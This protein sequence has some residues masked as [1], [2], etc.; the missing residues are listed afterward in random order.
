MGLR[1]LTGEETGSSKSSE[2]LSTIGELSALRL[3]RRNGRLGVSSCSSSV[4]SGERKEVLVEVFPER[5]VEVRIGSVTF[6]SVS[7]GR[8]R[9]R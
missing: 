3:G 7:A 5:F 2:S 4:S 8:R 9:F 1:L 6:D